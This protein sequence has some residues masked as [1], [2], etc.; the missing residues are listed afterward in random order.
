MKL[1]GGGK[2]A[3]AALLLDSIPCHLR[4]GDQAVDVAIELI[5]AAVPTTLRLDLAARVSD[6][7]QVRASLDEII[8]CVGHATIDSPSSC[9]TTNL[10]M[11]ANQYICY[12]YRNTG[13]CS[14]GSKCRF[15][16]DA[17]G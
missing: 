17:E 14:W 6:A 10:A 1:E 7:L 15:L 5:L 4:S 12:T 13:Q 16:H 8:E 3:A 11:V 9:G 2:P